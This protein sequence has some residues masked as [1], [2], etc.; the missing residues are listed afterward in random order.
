MV[1]KLRKRRTREEVYRDNRSLFTLDQLN[2]K[3][4]EFSIYKLM[5]V[6]QYP[7]HYKVI[8]QRSFAFFLPMY[9]EYCLLADFY[10]GTILRSHEISISLD[11][12]LV[13]PF[14][15]TLIKSIPLCV[16]HQ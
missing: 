7:L 16:L 15:E 2:S 11:F 14:S 6:F 10:T 3:I 9:A 12:I 4:S 1:A 5:I 13:G 8:K